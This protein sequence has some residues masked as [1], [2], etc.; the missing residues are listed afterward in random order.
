MNLMGIQELR[1]ARLAAAAEAAGA[2]SEPLTHACSHEAAD[3]ALV[4]VTDLARGARIRVQAGS[5]EAFD[6][7]ARSL[8]SASVLKLRG[9]GCGLV[10]LAPDAATLASG[11]WDG[12]GWLA[13]LAP[14]R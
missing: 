10:R 1:P 5:G 2:A 13:S 7:A 8:L 11:N 6:E 12:A 14:A 3:G 9:R 4:L